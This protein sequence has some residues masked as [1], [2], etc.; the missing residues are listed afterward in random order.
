MTSL[1]THCELNSIIMNHW[2]CISDFLWGR[3]PV[4]KVDG[5]EVFQT[6]VICRLLAERHD[7]LPS[8]DA[9]QR[10]RVEEVAGFVQDL[11]EGFSETFRRRLGFHVKNTFIRL[12]VVYM[13]ILTGNL[14]CC[15]RLEV[16]NKERKC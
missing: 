2:I 11:S 12:I 8:G 14:Q 9:V 16:R 10:A 1:K 3:V 7:L 13:K 5:S 6:L 4:L 15:S